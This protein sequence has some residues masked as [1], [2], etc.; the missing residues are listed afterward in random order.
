MHHFVAGGDIL[1]Q[2]R[3]LLTMADHADLAVAFWG[4]GAAEMLQLNATKQ[5]RIICDALSGGCNPTELRTLF[6]LSDRSQKRVQLRHLRG[7]HSKVYLTRQGAVVGSAN[8]STN[9]LGEEV[10]PGTIEAT[11]LTRSPTS[12]K[13]IQHWFDEMWKRALEVDEQT[14]RKARLAWIGTAPRPTDSGTTVFDL[15]F[16]NPSWFRNR[17]RLIVIEGESSPEADAAFGKF[18]RSQFSAQDLKHFDEIGFDPYYHNEAPV[19]DVEKIVRAGDYVIDCGNGSGVEVSRLRPNPHISFGADDSITLLEPRKD[20]LGLKFPRAQKLALSRAAR[21]FRK[22][23]KINPN[24]F[25]FYLDELPPDFIDLISLH[26]K[27]LS[28]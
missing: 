14:L 28:A 1:K 8:A 27:S 24:D 26:F 11:I 4:K 19:S 10:S 16:S 13:D 22:Q 23:R 21:D 7:L 2:V 3:D 18:G 15:L 9:G 17:V 25:G 6:E 20:V 5:T 12:L